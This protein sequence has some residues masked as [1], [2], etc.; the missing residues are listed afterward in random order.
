M[1]G[2]WPGPGHTRPS[3][4]HRPGQDRRVPPALRMPGQVLKV[5][6]AFPVWR[7]TESHSA[8]RRIADEQEHA[9]S[10]LRLE[11]KSGKV[12]KIGPEVGGL[13]Y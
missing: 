3:T 10:P 12:F 6:E 7:S 13:F 2:F 11:G 9:A 8:C 4:F 1:E 5:P